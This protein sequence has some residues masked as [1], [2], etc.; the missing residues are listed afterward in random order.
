[1]VD[2]CGAGLPATQRTCCCLSSV[3]RTALD[4]EQVD[5]CG[6]QGRR[7]SNVVVSGIRT[8]WRLTL[9]P[10]TTSLYGV[11]H[12]V[13][14]VDASQDAVVAAADRAMREDR[15]AWTTGPSVAG[16]VD[17]HVTVAPQD[18]EP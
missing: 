11:V 8:P 6:E 4:A 16:T 17:L 18:G 10:R 2:A 1:M 9:A 12:K 7:R 13:L 5:G 3:R 15:A 14:Q